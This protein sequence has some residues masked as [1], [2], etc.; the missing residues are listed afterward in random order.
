[1]REI[2]S[3]DGEQWK[4]QKSLWPLGSA[5]SKREEG[6]GE[7]KYEKRRSKKEVGGGRCGEENL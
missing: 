5:G 6:E 4:K 7:E 1:M 2:W 3:G